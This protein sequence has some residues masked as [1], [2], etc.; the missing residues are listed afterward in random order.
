[1]KSDKT[2]FYDVDTQRD[3]IL[4]DGKFHIAGAE[5]MVPTLKAIT[6]LAR[7]QKVR[8]VCSVD[9][10]VPGDPLLK[11]A[12]GPYPDH[13]MAGTPGQ[14]KIPE[15]EPLNPLVLETKEYS[16]DEIKKILQHQGE[17]VFR[18]QQFDAL[19]D[20]TQVR[21]ILRLVLQPYQDIVIYGVYTE[22]CA[23]REITSLIG[24]GPK[25]HVVKDAVAIIGDETPG[26]NQKLQ[27]EGVEMLS[28]DELKIQMLN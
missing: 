26:F 27:Q 28:F 25:L 7:E 17:I 5:K 23:D 1:M 16:T 6:D 18:R 24:L 10:H 20:S 3:F 22:A 13:C 11:S 2:I 19:A 15:T 12:G 9:C 14:K 21:A 8:L 4:P